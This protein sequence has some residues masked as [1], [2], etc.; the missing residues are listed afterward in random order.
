M[1]DTKLGVFPNFVFSRQ[2][3]LQTVKECFTLSL[4]AQFAVLIH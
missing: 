4:T 3:V 2:K 1:T